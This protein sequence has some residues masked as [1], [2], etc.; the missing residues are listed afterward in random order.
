MGVCMI[1]ALQ[2]PV[3]LNFSRAMIENTLHVMSESFSMLLRRHSQTASE[4]RVALISPASRLASILQIS[5]AAVLF[6]FLDRR[7]ANPPKER[8]RKARR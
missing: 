4:N 7:R 6:F 5:A 8:G 1:L 3:R 2:G